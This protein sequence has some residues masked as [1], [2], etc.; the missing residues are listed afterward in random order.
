MKLLLLLFRYW[1]SL[2]RE[3]LLQTN[4]LLVEDL[5]H[6]ALLLFSAS[7]G[8]HSLQ[9]LLTSYKKINMSSIFSIMRTGP[10]HK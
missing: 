6:A 7:L 2:G 10:L 1:G 9:D 3:C 4:R 5:L 8:I